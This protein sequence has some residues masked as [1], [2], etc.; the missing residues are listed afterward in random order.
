MKKIIIVLIIILVLIF[1]IQNTESVTVNFLNFS[2][3]MPGSV[4]IIITLLFGFFIGP[5]IPPINKGSKK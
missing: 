1:I 5:L 3:R 4:I 2:A